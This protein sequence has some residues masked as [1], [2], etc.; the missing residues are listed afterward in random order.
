MVRSERKLV[1]RTLQFAP[2][3]DVWREM[4]AVDVGLR[5]FRP[6]EFSQWCLVRK[7]CRRELSRRYHIAA[8]EPWQS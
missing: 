4:T 7:T 5:P 1:E 2:A 3:A 8:K 6:L